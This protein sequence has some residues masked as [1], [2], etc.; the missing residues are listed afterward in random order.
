MKVHTFVASLIFSDLLNVMARDGRKSRSN[1]G[2]KKIAKK[3][4][5]IRDTIHCHKVFIN[6]TQTVTLIP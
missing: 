4:H 5:Q 1:G 2:E 6:L 3:N